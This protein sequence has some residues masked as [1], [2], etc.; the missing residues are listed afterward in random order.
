MI[1]VGENPFNGQ[2]CRVE[3]KWG[4]SQAKRVHQIIII[5]IIIII[6]QY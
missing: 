6:I 1:G 3:D 5:I 2:R 4:G